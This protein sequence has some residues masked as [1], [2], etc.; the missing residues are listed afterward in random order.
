M[1][2]LPTPGTPVTS[3]RKPSAKRK[4]RAGLNPRATPLEDTPNPPTEPVP[5]P[6]IA[7]LAPTPKARAGSLESRLAQAFAG[8][9]PLPAF[10]GDQ[11]SAFILA[12]RSAKFAHDL[13]EL[14]KVNTKLKK[15]LEGMLDGG[16]YG[17]VIFSGAA[18][19]LPI[20]WGYGILPHPGF[21]PFQA[22]YPTVPP[23]IMPRSATAGRSKP[24]G[25]GNS[26]G[27]RVP[28]EAPS[29]TPE[30]SRPETPPGVVTVPPGA[31]PPVHPAAS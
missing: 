7:Q 29:A 6:E 20:A 27:A 1:S 22:F 30:G 17:G 3:K 10:M 19:L 5:E 4:P 23:G 9:S 15:M 11:Y 18:M 24:T 25:G 31:H 21:D 16:A 13:A 28:V 8:V 12:S 2:L 26:G 14:A